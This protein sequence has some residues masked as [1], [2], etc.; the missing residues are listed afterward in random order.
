MHDDDY[1]SDRMDFKMIFP[2]NGR[3]PKT[4]PKFS[5]RKDPRKTKTVRHLHD[6]GVR[7]LPTE[8]AHSNG[9]DVKT[10]I[11]SIILKNPRISVDD[12]IDK[13]DEDADAVSRFL[14][15]EI[16]REFRHSL[17]FLKALDVNVGDIDI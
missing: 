9:R 4:D 8:Q 13:L 16:R 2:N 5:Q 6:F 11:K 10:R 7:P 1:D 12:L 15:C 3:R 14:V 17:K